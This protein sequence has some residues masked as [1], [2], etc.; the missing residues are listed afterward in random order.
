MD[1]VRRIRFQDKDYVL[2]GG[3]YVP[4]AAIAT[5]EAYANFEPSYAHLMPDGRIMRFG[6]QIGQESDITYLPDEEQA[7]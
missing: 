1:T 6:K 7:A 3:K 4:G 5:P 2:V